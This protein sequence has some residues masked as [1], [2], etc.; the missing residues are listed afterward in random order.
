MPY[1]PVDLYRD[2]LP[3]TNCKDC[4]LSTCLAFAAKVVAEHLPLSQ[5]PHLDPDG[6]ADVQKALDEQYDS[7]KWKKRDMAEDALEWARQRAASMEIKDLEPRIGGRTVNMEG[8][9]VLLL[10]YFLEHIIITADGMEKEKGGE[11]TRLEQTFLYNHLAQGGILKP[12]G[13][14]TGFQELP[15]TVSKIKSMRDHVEKPLVECF[16]GRIKELKEISKQNGAADVSDTFGSSGTALRFDPLP[17]LPVLLLF[18]D[19]DEEF[20]AECRLLF[21]ETVTEH[22][23]IES[24]LFLS[25]RLKDLLIHGA[26]DPTQQP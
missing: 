6:I 4:G 1:S 8:R 10:P 16:S 9:T 15:N 23:D 5:C 11:L 22:L 2:I 12:T 20:D 13:K 7:G 26:D 3:K 25:E 18:W 21:D 17:R 24:I 14:W 19:A